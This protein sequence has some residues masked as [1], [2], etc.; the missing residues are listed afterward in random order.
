MF[1]GTE[2]NSLFM[3]RTARERTF[4]GYGV[5]KRYLGVIG[6]EVLGLAALVPGGH[7]PQ[8]DAPRQEEVEDLLARPERPRLQNGRHRDLAVP[9]LHS[10]RGFVLLVCLPV[11]F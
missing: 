7:A 11:G 4:Q 8:V 5:K 3:G 6:G 9:V 10:H 1:S 2:T